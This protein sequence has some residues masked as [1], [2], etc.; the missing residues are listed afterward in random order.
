MRRIAAALALGAATLALPTLALPALAAEPLRVGETFLVAGLDPA[1]G[2][3]GWALTSHGIGDGLWT[4]NAAGELVPD[5]ATSAE[6]TGELTWTVRL[7]EGRKFSNGAPVTAAALKLGFDN[8]FAK[9][10]PA[11]A[12]G[13]R[14]SFETM[15]D[16]TL[17]VTTERPVAML[18]A[19]FAEWPLVAYTLDADGTAVFTG[20][21]EIVVLK[22][23]ESLTLSPNPNYPGAAERAPVVIRRFGD[24][25]TMALALQA[26]ELDL[27]FGLATEGLAGI[28]ADPDLTVKSFPVGYQYFGFLNTVR[29]S[30]ADVRVRQAIDLGLDRAE[31]V[32]AIG[33]GAPATGAFA[34]Y[35]PFAGTEPR[36]TDTARAAALLDAAGWKAGP[37][38]LRAKDGA[39]LTLTVVTYSSRPDLVTML[40]VVAAELGR[41]GIATETSVVETP[42]DVA[43][44]GNFDIF[45]WAQHTAPSGDPAFFFNSMLV[46][47]A[48]LNFAQ[49]ASPAFDAIVA[50]F[51]ETADPADRAAIAGEAQAQLFADVPVTFLVAPDWRVGLS[52]R[53]R[54][55]A[56]WGSDYHVVRADM[57]ETR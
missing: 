55:Y 6:R 47:G 32:A 27:A 49:Y 39:P 46:S 13:G 10:A 11:A 1:Q 45:L 41:L 8:T 19:L 43:A 14:L 53:L 36:T 28:K 2:S 9:N 12:T 15:D 29:P 5:L 24:A 18:P 25:Q 16:L 26:G 21:Y 52:P 30:L 50:K 56:P 7:A 34:P 51:A 48:S 44:E 35:F 20:P 23:D 4:V 3:A 38:G 42:N 37:D 40:P 54:G 31:L 57:G 17:L 33:N 22:P